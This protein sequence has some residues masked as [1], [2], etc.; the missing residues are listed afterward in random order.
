MQYDLSE[1][2]KQEWTTQYSILESDFDHF[3]RASDI[4]TSQIVKALQSDHEF[5]LE[6]LRSE[7]QETITQMKN[8]QQKTQVIATTTDVQIDQPQT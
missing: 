3:R 8:E 2:S 7:H 6:K 4:K 1:E 5:E